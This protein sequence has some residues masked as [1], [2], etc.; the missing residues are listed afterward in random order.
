[1]ATVSVIVPVLNREHT[2]LRCLESILNQSRIPEEII[3]VDNGS[4]DLTVKKVK[5]WTARIVNRDLKVKLLIEPVEGACAARQRGLEEAKSDYVIFF[6]SDDAMRPELIKK[7]LSVINKESKTDIVC[8]KCEIEQL[9]GSKRIP[10]FIPQDPFRGHLIHTLL[11][12]QG[13]MVRK[14]FLEKAG[15]WKKNIKVWND[16]ETGFR[17]LLNDPVINSMDE[18]LA[19]IYAQ[20][21]SI[22]G[23]NFSSKR[24][25]W[26]TTIDEM[27]QLNDSNNHSEKIRIKKIINY[28]RAILGAMYYKEGNRDAATKLLKSSLRDISSKDKIINYVSYLYTRKGGRGAWLLTYFL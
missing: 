20:E 12:P 7:A 21:N 11:R 13:Y 4:S 14:D 23:K 9:D 19:D 17:L 16:L 10:S 6:D 2:I 8:W 28:R 22:T 24:G 25:L 1:M 15:G 27:E 3:I 5:D 18:V 26:E